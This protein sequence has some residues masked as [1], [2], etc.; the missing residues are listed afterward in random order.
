MRSNHRPSGG[1]LQLGGISSARYSES[2]WACV[3]IESSHSVRGPV[4]TSEMEIR[5]DNDLT[6]KHSWWKP[7]LLQGTKWARLATFLITKFSFDYKVTALGAGAASRGRGSSRVF[8]GVGA[9][10]TTEPTK[11]PQIRTSYTAILLMLILFNRRAKGTVLNG[12][13]LDFEFLDPFLLRFN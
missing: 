4:P 13:N 7:W 10:S 6:L 8:P 11:K 3:G 2:Q 12:T 5:W 9:W 1:S